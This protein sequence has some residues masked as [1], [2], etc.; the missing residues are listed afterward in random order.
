MPELPEVETVRRGVDAVAVGRR[1]GTVVATGART[2]RRTSFGAVIGGASDRAVVGTGRHGKWFWL[3]LEDEAQV[4]IHLRM[5]GQLL[6]LP[7]GPLATG[8]PKHTHVAFPFTDGSELQFVD[9]RT[10]GEVIVVPPEDSLVDLI[11][12]GPDALTV[13]VDQLRTMLAGRSRPVKALLLDQKMVAGIGNIYADEICFRAGIRPLGSAERLTKP[14]VARL[15]KAIVSILSAAIEA[16][17][18]SLADEQY[19]DLFGVTGSYQRQHRVHARA[20][21]P[22]FDCDSIIRRVVLGGRSTY[23]CPTCQR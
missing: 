19:V 23:F 8:R 6:W 10:F 22:C 11:G 13:D 1:L 3:T 4:L 2:V 16:R 5:S 7:G 14:S 17:G 15:Q 9:P 18:S 21:S 20:G 12:Q